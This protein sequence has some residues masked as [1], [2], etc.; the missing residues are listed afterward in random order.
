MR[1]A[2]ILLLIGTTAFS[3]SVFKFARRGEHLRVT[4]TVQTPFRTLA[5]RA[6]EREQQKQV[7]NRPLGIQATYRQNFTRPYKVIG[8]NSYLRGVGRKFKGR[9]GWERIE[10]S[11]SYNGAHHI[12]TKSVIKQIS[13]KDGEIVNNAPSVFHPLH[14]NKSFD[15]DFHDHARQL[16]LYREHG[17]RA[18]IIDFF[19]RINAINEA[20][21][22]PKYEQADID[23]ELIEAELWARHWGL[24]W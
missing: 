1:V 22:L 23:K 12:V 21:G 6:I 16:E 17:I 8:P 2:L 24:K 11:G 10:Q 7:F 14:N 19:E 5:R 18:I 9:K 3:Q 20:L 4:R 13:G 15:K